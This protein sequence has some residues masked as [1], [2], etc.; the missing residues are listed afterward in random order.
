VKLY[1]ICKKFHEKLR[2]VVR[3]LQKVSRKAA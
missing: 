3:N 1:E 2:E